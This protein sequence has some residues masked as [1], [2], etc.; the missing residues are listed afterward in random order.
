MAVT[1]VEVVSNSV[2][3]VLQR[4]SEVDGVCLQGPSK[5]DLIQYEGAPELTQE[6]R[7]FGDDCCPGTEC[8]RTSEGWNLHYLSL[9]VDKNWKE[10]AMLVP[11]KRK[12]VWSINGGEQ[13]TVQLTRKQVAAGKLES[14][15]GCGLVYDEP[16]CDALDD[17]AAGFTCRCDGGGYHVSYE[18]EREGAGFVL[19]GIAEDSH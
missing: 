15:P 5:L 3:V 8:V 14:A 9:L 2:S 10:L 4:R 18:W 16:N 19:V 17:K 1:R 13:P 11:T 7:H 6:I 12:L